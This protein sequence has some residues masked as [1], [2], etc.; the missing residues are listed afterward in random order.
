MDNWK[1]ILIFHN[2][3]VSEKI[4]N[5]YIQVVPFDDP[6]T[7][8]IRSRS[9]EFSNFIDNFKDQFDRPC[10]PGVLF[11]RSDIQLDI[12]AIVSFRNALAISS[13]SN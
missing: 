5:D 10:H 9:N 4:G 6:M 11:I 7:D 2:L 8:H 13:I 1:F 12:E 3:P